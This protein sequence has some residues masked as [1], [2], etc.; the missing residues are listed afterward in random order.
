MVELIES[1]KPPGIMAGKLYPLIQV[2]DDVCSTMHAVSEGA[3]EKFVQVSFRFSNLQKLS[4]NCSNHKHF[5]GMQRQFIVQHYAG[6]VTYDC[7]GFVENNK[8]TL[9]RDLIQLMQS[10]SR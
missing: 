3:D 1:K 9:F 5:V 8:D 7:D 10:T 6:N 2:L 4:L